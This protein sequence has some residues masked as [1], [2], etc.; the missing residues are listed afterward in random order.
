MDYPTLY[1]IAL[2][3]I[4]IQPTSVPCERVFSS[5]ADTDTKKRSRITAPLMEA[6]QMLKFNLKHQDE[7]WTALTD[8]KLLEQPVETDEDLLAS[9]LNDRGDAVLELAIKDDDTT[10]T[11]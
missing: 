1:A 3:Y 10:Y 2:D 11:Y 5:S 4:P 7:S 8:D 9:L 6:I